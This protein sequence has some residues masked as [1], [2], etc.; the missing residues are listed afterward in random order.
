MRHAR[1]ALV[2][3]LA[4]VLLLV[5]S[6]AWADGITW[7]LT[8]VDLSDGGAVTG[9]FC[10]NAT[11]NAYSAINV[12]STSGLLLAGTLYTTLTP[13]YFSGSTL[14]G[15][16]PATLP[17]DYSGLTFL[18]L[19]FTNPLTSAGVPDPVYAVETY[20]QD[21]QCNATIIRTSLTGSVTANPV[22]APEPASLFLLALGLLAVA[23]FRRFS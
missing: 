22:P 17:S 9:S 14:L 20:C 13:A 6:H 11:S 23:F 19:I 4:V 10:Y 16:G 15:L 2:A 8:G 3:A 1:F 18:Q 12:S 21:S 7:S 5:P